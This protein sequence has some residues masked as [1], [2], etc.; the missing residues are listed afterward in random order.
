MVLA[1]ALTRPILQPHGKENRQRSAARQLPELVQEDS[2]V[3]AAVT[4]LK[5][6]LLVVWL[7]LF[8]RCW[9]ISANGKL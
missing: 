5:R 4:A 1:V 8:V 3:G 6:A 9:L 7:S 2:R